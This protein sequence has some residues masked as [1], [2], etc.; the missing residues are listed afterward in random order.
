M[1]YRHGEALYEIQVENPEH[2][3]RGVTWVEIDGKRLKDG[4]IT[5]DQDLVKHHVVVRMGQPQQAGKVKKT[6]LRSPDK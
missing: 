4:L 1:S 6:R 3:E 2:C 5:L